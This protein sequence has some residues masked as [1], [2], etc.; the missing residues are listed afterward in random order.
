MNGRKQGGNRAKPD[1]VRQGGDLGRVIAKWPFVVSVLLW[2]KDERIRHEDQTLHT[3]EV[4]CLEQ[5]YSSLWAELGL[6]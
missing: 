6:D 5:E 3:E 2:L 1:R 4:I